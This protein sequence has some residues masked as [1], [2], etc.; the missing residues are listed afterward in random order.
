[1]GARHGARMTG[2]RQVSSRGLGTQRV[3][4]PSN[5]GAEGERVLFTFIGVGSG[6]LVMLLANVLAKRDAKAPPTRSQPE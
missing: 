1:M 5:L 2:P 6:V 3:G 4:R